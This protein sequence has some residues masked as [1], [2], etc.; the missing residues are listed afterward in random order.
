MC[1][2]SSSLEESSNKLEVLQF[3]LKLMLM[4]PG[5]RFIVVLWEK[6]NSPSLVALRES[7]GRYFSYAPVLSAF[8]YVPHSLQGRGA[9]PPP[10]SLYIGSCMLG[11]QFS[12]SSPLCSFAQKDQER[13]E[14]S[15]LMPLVSSHHKI[16]AIL[17]HHK[18][19]FLRGT[20]Q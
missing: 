9:V 6:I 16:N 14:T 13:K 2:A 5:H 3:Q 19:N 17:N 7:T 11:N 10:G 4:T 18:Y 12:W 20:C 15:V 1:S 8:R